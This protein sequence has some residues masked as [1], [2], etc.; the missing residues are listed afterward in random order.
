M[1]QCASEGVES[2]DCP[3]QQTDCAVLWKCVGDL[4][5]RLATVNMLGRYVFEVFRHA[6]RWTSDEHTH[7]RMD[8]TAAGFKAVLLFEA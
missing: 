2:D 5:L 8:T 6:H 7:M 4:C 1:T 3:C